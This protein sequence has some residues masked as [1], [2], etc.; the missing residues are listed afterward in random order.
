L[1]QDRDELLERSA[2][3]ETR[4][5]LATPARQAHKRPSAAMKRDP[6]RWTCFLP[7]VFTGIAAISPAFIG[8]GV[9]PL[10][11]VFAVVWLMLAVAIARAVGRNV[12]H[13]G[14]GPKS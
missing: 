11:L 6:L 2:A 8:R 3:N 4:D 12:S 5:V 13:T 10:L 9:N 14:A 7:G 1:P